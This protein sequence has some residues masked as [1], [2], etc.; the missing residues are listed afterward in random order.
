MFLPPIGNLGASSSMNQTTTMLQ[1]REMILR[2]ELAPGERMR[3]A[4]L[5]TRLGISR[6]PVRQALPALAQEGLLVRSGQRGF[7][8]GESLEVLRLRALL[9]GFAARQLAERGVKASFLDALR[10][11]LRAGDALFSTRTLHE[12]DEVRYGEM[13]LRFHS[14][15]LEGAGMPLLA[16]F[17]A[18][19][20]LVP[21]T[22]PDS[23][24][25]SAVGR[26][27]MFDLLFYAHRQ[28]HS[29]VEAIVARQADRAEFLFREHAVGQEHSMSLQQGN[30]ALLSG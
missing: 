13:N 15:V 8:P 9:E 21:F 6:T 16:S 30:S 4:D 29:I 17:A 25:F 10:D 28:H 26:Q 20:N 5:A 3:E 19:C 27:A 22:S 24:A 18:R 14:L 7:G 2:G 23:I 12:D 11:T 1:L